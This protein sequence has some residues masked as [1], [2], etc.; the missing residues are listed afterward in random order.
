IATREPGGAPGAEDIR[1]L[2]LGKAEGHWDPMTELMLT[3]AARREHLVRT[4]WP[5]LEKGIW[6]VSD[7]FVDSARVYQGIG[8]G[9]GLEKV[10]AIYEEIAGDFWPDLTLLLDVPVET[11]LERMASRC[12]PDDRYQRQHKKFHE[13][14]RAGFLDLAKMEP[15]RFN[16]ID[17]SQ[18]QDKVTADIRT[19]VTQFFALTGNA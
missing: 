16:V 2:W 1:S 5:A 6:V 7:R 8:L 11:G 19:A 12:G 10:D 9:L 4:V 14:L 13:M 18:N 3:M 15:H 17:A